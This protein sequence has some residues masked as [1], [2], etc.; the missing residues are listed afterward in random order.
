MCIE[1]VGVG[2]R[3]DLENRRRSFRPL[4]VRKILLSVDSASKLTIHS[5]PVN[6]SRRLKPHTEMLKQYSTKVCLVE[7]ARLASFLTIICIRR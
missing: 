1:E 3:A 6:W 4:K 2:Q 5:Q 7:S